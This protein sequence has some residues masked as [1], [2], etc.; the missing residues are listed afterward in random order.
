MGLD[1]L[2]KRSQPTFP[3]SFE[4]IIIP[5][6]L[7]LSKIDILP[8]QARNFPSP[9]PFSCRSFCLEFPTL[10]SKSNLYQSACMGAHAHTHTH[11]HTYTHTHSTWKILIHL[12]KTRTGASGG[13]VAKALCSQCRGPGFDSCFGNKIPHA[14]T[15]SSKRSQLKILHAVV[16]I[17][18]PT[19]CN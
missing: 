11:T 9:V 8:E 15:E 18:D 5:H 4:A 2:H 14:A 12:L 1:A 16:K 10:L 17:E 3:V 19:C 7:C 6:A 13:P